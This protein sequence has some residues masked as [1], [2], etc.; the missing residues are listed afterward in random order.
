[1]RITTN[2]FTKPFLNN[3]NNLQESKFKNE[4]RIDSGKKNLSLSDSPVDVVKSKEISEKID[5][6]LSY[7]NNIQESY[8]EMQITNDY[9]ESISEK[10]SEMRN[11]AIE[12]ASPAN[13]SNIPT[14]SQIVKSKLEDI[15]KDSNAEHN[16]KYIF[17]GTK[18]TANSL[19]EPDGT[20][21]SVPFELVQDTPTTDNPSGLV[22]RFYGNMKDREFNRDSYNTEKVNTTADTL[23]KTDG[24][25]ALNE[26]VKLYNVMAFNEDG[27]PRTELN[28]YTKAD[29]DKLNDIQQ[30]IAN[31]NENILRANSINGSKTNRIL[32]V[33]DQMTEENLRLKSML[34]IVNDTDYAKTMMDLMK[35]KN[36]IDYSLQAGAKMQTTSLFNFIS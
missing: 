29:T 35:D 3:L 27:T 34:S 8:S 25:E 16:G 21:H 15:I 17:S 18:T 14:L 33:N 30:N 26:L 22:V 10:M 6:N 20:T 28:N 1:M 9:I 32:A 31:N 23:F 2:S 24:V 12:S 5:R 13:N 11:L 7:I 36:A 19:T 4:I